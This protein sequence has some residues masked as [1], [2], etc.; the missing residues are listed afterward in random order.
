MQVWFQNRRAK[1]RKREKALGRETTPYIQPQEQP[2]YPTEF[3]YQSPLR[4]PTLSH[5]F[6]PNF[7]FPPMFNPSMSS[8]PWGVKTP[9]PF[10]ALLSQYM[11]L[12]GGMPRFGLHP[13]PEERSRSVSPETISS[14]TSRV[15]PPSIEAYVN[16]TPENLKVQAKS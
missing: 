11:H 12:S 2:V 15:T 14:S 16:R 7:T 5:E 4:L 6:W 8:L 10:H 3:N 13:M 9:L 1:W